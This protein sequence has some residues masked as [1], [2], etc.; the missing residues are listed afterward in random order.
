[1]CI[2]IISG[3]DPTILLQPMEKTLYNVATF[4]HL[5]IIRPIINAVPARTDHRNRPL[6]NN[7]FSQRI[8][9]ISRIRNDVLAGVAGNQR[10]GLCHVMTRTGCQG[11]T[12][13]NKRIIYRSIEFRGKAT[14]APTECF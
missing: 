9:V 14:L 3:G 6:G 7:R 2:F 8:G 4:I 10:R 5:F 1:M 11:K 13:R 12:Q